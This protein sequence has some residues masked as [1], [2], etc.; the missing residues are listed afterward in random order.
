VL[1]NGVTGTAFF[2][3]SLSYTGDFACRTLRQRAVCRSDA[4]CVLSADETGR[5]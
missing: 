4:P 3:G 1:S 2:V 5:A